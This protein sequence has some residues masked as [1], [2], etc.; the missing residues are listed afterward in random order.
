MLDRSKIRNAAML[1]PQVAKHEHV[2]AEIMKD[3]SRKCLECG[4]IKIEVK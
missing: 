2:F 3:G 4:K 1:K